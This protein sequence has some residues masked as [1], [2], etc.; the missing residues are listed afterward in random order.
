MNFEDV[1]IVLSVRKYGE[2]A[3][4]IELL[5]KNHGRHIGLARNYQSKNN[6]PILQPGNAISFIW[7]ARLSEHLGTVTFELDTSRSWKLINNRVRMV[8]LQTLISHLRMLPERESFPE[9][10]KRTSSILDFTCDDSNLI[11]DLI[12][13]EL[14]ILEQLGYGVDMSE[15]AVTKSNQ[16]LKYI[17]P[18]TGRAVTKEVGEPYKSKLIEIPEFIFGGN[19]LNDV[20]LKKGL[21]LTEFFLKKDL[22]KPLQL[23]LPMFRDSLYQMLSN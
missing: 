4:L 2:R 14:F 3:G 15:C 8:V 21:L 11:K 5:T 12:I 7:K 17:S 18:R 20:E 1:G 16:D 6:Q 13:W 9:V 23:N 19:T 10:F 22:Y